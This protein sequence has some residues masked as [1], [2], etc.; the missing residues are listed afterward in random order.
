MMNIFDSI[1][2]IYQT[3]I[4]G[5]IIMLPIAALQTN[6]NI[7]NAMIGPSKFTNALQRRGVC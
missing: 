2:L 7:E 5:I 3:I 1:T 6:I 4:I